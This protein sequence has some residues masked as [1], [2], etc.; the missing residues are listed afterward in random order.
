VSRVDMKLIGRY[1]VITFLY[2]LSWYILQ[3]TFIADV[4]GM[5]M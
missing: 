1:A 5:V 3:P 4:K 2:Y